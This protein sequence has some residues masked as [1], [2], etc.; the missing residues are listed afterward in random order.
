MRILF[1]ANSINLGGAFKTCKHLAE[2]IRR[3]QGGFVI[4]LATVA[5]SSA[6][7]P[8]DHEFD[9]IHE[10][11]DS[12]AL[13]KL[14]GSGRFDLVHWWKSNSDS[15]FNDTFSNL[16][17]RPPLL[18]TLCQ[19]P[20]RAKYGLSLANYRY[21]DRV[22]FVCKSAKAHWR[23][24]DF[25][26]SSSNVIYFGTFSQKYGD[27]H[28]Y[29]E[30]RK[31]CEVVFGRGS[32]LGKCPSWA[33][34]AFVDAGLGS[35][36]FQIAGSGDELQKQRL[37]SRIDH[38]DESDRIKLLGQ[39]NE[40]DWLKVVAGFDIF[41]YGISREGFSAIDGTMQD[42]MLMGVPV[43]Y[44]GAPGP[45]ELVEHGVTGYVANSYQ[46]FVQYARRLAVDE[47]KRVEM[48]LRARQRIEDHFSYSATLQSYLGLYGSMIG[49]KGR[50]KNY[51]PVRRV[52]VKFLVLRVTDSAIDGAKSLFLKVRKYCFK[53][54]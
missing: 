27:S 7:L 43:V 5:A 17:E 20:S 44:F 54:K 24:R 47:G 40:R 41:F 8:G 9:A 2:S 31:R 1:V 33:I 25:P 28:G 39:L 22:V 18:L 36:V 34:D 32:S 38:F 13:R 19:V 3:E 46:E 29:T 50:T 30:A 6:S 12:A 51:G 4:E 10:A 49:T 53:L 15:C 52:P 42:A 48:G 14:I 23:V 35:S 16:I 45:A 11:L 21:C 37:E 26:E